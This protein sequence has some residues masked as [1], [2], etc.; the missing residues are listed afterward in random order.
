[1]VQVLRSIPVAVI[2]PN[3]AHDFV[4]FELGCLFDCFFGC[5]FSFVFRQDDAAAASDATQHD[6]D[7]AA[8]GGLQ[9]GVVTVPE[10]DADNVGRGGPRE[11]PG[12]LAPLLHQVAGFDLHRGQQRFQ[13][14]SRSSQGASEAVARAR[15]QRGEAAGVRQQ[16]RRAQL[17]E[18]RRPH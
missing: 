3:S 8:H 15:A 18:C 4:G 16:T 6:A 2:A 5:L 7:I 13:P 11:D 10:P 9:P 14:D 17:L 12:A 1:M